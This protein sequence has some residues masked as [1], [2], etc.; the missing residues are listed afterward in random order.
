[1]KQLNYEEYLDNDIFYTRNELKSER[2]VIYKNTLYIKSS[3]FYK[4]YFHENTPIKDLFIKF[5]TQKGLFQFL[6]SMLEDK[7]ISYIEFNYNDEVKRIKLKDFFSFYISYSVA[8][9]A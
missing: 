2:S 8:S 4:N 9:F 5:I 7:N 6:L 3:S 1:M